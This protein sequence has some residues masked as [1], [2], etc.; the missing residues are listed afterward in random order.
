MQR[1][2]ASELK[3]KQTEMQR[4]IE[5]CLAQISTLEAQKAALTKDNEKLKSDV[6]G[7]DKLAIVNKENGNT[8]SICSTYSI[9]MYRH[10]QRGDEDTPGRCEVC[11]IPIE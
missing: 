6:Q 2:S 8:Y 9:P 11:H 3:E 10:S 1:G 5:K 7:L 4:D